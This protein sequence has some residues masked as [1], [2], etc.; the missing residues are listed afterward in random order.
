MGDFRM[1]PRG[2]PA[3]IDP[4][5]LQ[6]SKVKMPVL[7]GGCNQPFPAKDIL[8]YH[9]KRLCRACYDL[10]ERSRKTEALLSVVKEILTRKIDASGRIDGQQEGAIELNATRKAFIAEFGGETTFGTKWAQ[11]LKMVHDRAMTEHKNVNV[12][13]KMYMDAAKF[14]EAAK[15]REVAGFQKLT[16]EQMKEQQAIALASYMRDAAVAEAM[17]RMID[18]VEASAMRGDDMDDIIEKFDRML[19]TPIPQPKLGG[20]VAGHAVPT[21]KP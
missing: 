5:D 6:Y 9:G 12:A 10:E 18:L 2:L 19:T 8:H 13:A 21:V 20:T 15:D 7:C 3:G 17:Q 16:L 14:L 1:E 11:L 4:V